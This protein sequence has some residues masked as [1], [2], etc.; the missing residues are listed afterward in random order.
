[1]AYGLYVY[2]AWGYYPKVEPLDG[3]DGPI[4]AL[5]PVNDGGVGWSGRTGGVAV[6]GAHFPKHVRWADPNGNPAPDFDQT[7]CLNVSER[8]RRVIEEME[9]G[10]HQFFPVEYVDAK[11]AF[12]ENRHWLVVGNR[13]DAMDRQHTN[14]V[15]R[16][17]VVW[18]PADYIASRGE[19]VPAHID[20]TEPA[21]L[22]FSLK[23]IGSVHLWVDKHLDGPSTWLSDALAERFT[24]EK[25]TGLRLSESK[26]K[27]V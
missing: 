23:A 18:R 8:A 1:M 24:A 2:P 4:S 22:V 6:D 11:G 13:I 27:T 15:L 3:F 25:L 14:M 17:G 26:V 21:R 19:P 20:P 7:P 12:L 10:V 5:N 16:D 9:P